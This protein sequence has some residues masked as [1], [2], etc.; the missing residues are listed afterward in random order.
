MFAQVINGSD[1]QFI[2]K[3]AHL[4]VDLSPSS[5]KDNFYLGLLE[6]SR[7]PEWCDNVILIGNMNAKIIWLHSNEAQ[8]GIL[9]SLHSYGL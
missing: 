6:L 3:S 5:L 8:L 9:F 2:S 1:R 7:K 4:P